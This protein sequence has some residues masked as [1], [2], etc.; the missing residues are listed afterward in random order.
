[1]ASEDK[2]EETSRDDSTTECKSSSPATDHSLLDATSVRRAFERRDA[3]WT[4]ALASAEAASK[5][6]ANGAMMAGAYE[7]QERPRPLGDVLRD[8]A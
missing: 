1:M 6:F 4:E 5:V 7:K 8:L 2:D 3:E